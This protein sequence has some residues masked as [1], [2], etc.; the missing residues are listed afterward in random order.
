MRSY[1]ARVSRMRR[2]RSRSDLE[3][4]RMTSPIFD[5]KPDIRRGP[6]YRLHDV[7]SCTPLALC[8][9]ASQCFGRVDLRNFHS[10]PLIVVG[11]GLKLTRNRVVGHGLGNAKQTSRCFQV[12]LA[13]L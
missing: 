3:V 13:S 8:V 6:L 5:S 2:A 12:F 10:S 9:G 7:G 4:N 1:V 11:K